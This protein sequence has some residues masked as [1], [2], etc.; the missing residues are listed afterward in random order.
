M[1][2]EHL[3]KKMNKYYEMRPL[4]PSKYLELQF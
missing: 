2:C 1:F 3:C 4:E